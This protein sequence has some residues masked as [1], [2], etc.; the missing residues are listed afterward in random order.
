MILYLGRAAIYLLRL[1][2]PA[3]NARNTGS[4]AR[5]AVREKEGRRELVPSIW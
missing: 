3:D 2:V 1:S 4:Y 5:R